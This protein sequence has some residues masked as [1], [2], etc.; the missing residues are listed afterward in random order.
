MNFFTSTHAISLFPKTTFL[1][2]KTLMA[3]YFPDKGGDITSM[4]YLVQGG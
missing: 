1:D 2:R 3:R 4:A